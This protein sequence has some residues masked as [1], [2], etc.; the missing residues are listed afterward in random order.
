MKKSDK[1]RYPIGNFQYGKKYSLDETRKHIKTIARLPKQLKKVLKK[2]SSQALAT[3][4]RPGGWTVRQ[5]INHLADSHMNA[6]VRMKLTVTEPTPII[7]PYEEAL[8][9]ET[10]DGKGGSVKNTLRLLSALH[11]RWVQFLES[12]SEEDLERGYF[13]PERQSVILLPEAIALYAWHSKHHLA[14]IGLVA[15]GK[16]ASD[17]MVPSVGARRGRPKA[18]SM[19]DQPKLSRAEILAKARAARAA[20][21]SEQAPAKPARAKTAKKTADQPKLSRAEILAKARAARA[22]KKADQAP[23]KTA[24]PKTAKKTADQ[25]KLSRA[26]ILANAR[27]AR[28]AKKAEPADRKSVV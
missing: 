28:A 16:A 13:H 27:A 14:H 11:Q 17:T 15:S 23:A 24:K 2:M 19:A 18:S 9:A 8:W 1:Q 25:P 12:L 7:K 21:L 22:A 26:E 10:E 20:K 5:V 6:Y 3:P 4:Y